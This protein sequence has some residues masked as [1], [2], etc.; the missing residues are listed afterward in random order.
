MWIIELLSTHSFTVDVDL[1]VPTTKKIH[2]QLSRSS[3]TNK[4]S[5]W[6]T[7]LDQNSSLVSITD[8]KHQNWLSNQ[9]TG[10]QA[11]HME[12]LAICTHPLFGRGTVTHKNGP[13]ALLRPS[14]PQ[15]QR[16]I[17][18]SHHF[19]LLDPLHP[20]LFAMNMT[21]LQFSPGFHSWKI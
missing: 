6:L 1:E 13:L 17:Q 10:F 18:R 20:C 3:N 11:V 9:Q 15:L 2:W 16:L 4:N 12:H 19:H 8:Q 5:S 21:A 7:T 14:Y